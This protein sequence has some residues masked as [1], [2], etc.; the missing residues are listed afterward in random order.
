MAPLT[1]SVVARFNNAFKGNPRYT[2]SLSPIALSSA[3]VNA[4]KFRF[5][6]SIPIPADSAQNIVIEAADRIFGP[7]CAIAGGFPT[8]LLGKTTEYGDINFVLVYEATSAALLWT[9][10]FVDL[11]KYKFASELDSTKKWHFEAVGCSYEDVEDLPEHISVSFS[12]EIAVETKLRLYEKGVLV[13]DFTPFECK[14]TPKSTCDP[15]LL[16]VSTRHLYELAAVLRERYDTPIAMSIARVPPER[17]QGEMGLE[18]YDISG[19]LS[20]EK[21]LDWRYRPRFIDSL[22]TNN[23]STKYAK[24]LSRSYKT[25]CTEMRRLL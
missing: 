23:R 17:N 18:C 25:H 1:R 2:V 7:R 24:R 6:E 9:R 10:F 8:F 22:K 3:A 5:F 13:A 4:Y 15:L 21:K 11:V 19:V 16:E 20:E 14:G 12:E